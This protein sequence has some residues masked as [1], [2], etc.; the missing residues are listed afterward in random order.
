VTIGFTV[1]GATTVQIIVFTIDT[2]ENP[3][4]T[5]DIT[6]IDVNYVDDGGT[7]N[8]S[9]VASIDDLEPDTLDSAPTIVGTG[10]IGAVGQSI[11]VSF[12]NKNDIPSNGLIQLIFPEYTSENEFVSVSNPACSSSAGMPATPTCSFLDSSK[13]LTLSGFATSSIADSTTIT[14]T[15]GSIRNP[16][17]AKTKYGFTIYTLDQDSGYIDNY[18]STSTDFGFSITSIATFSSASLDRRFQVT[19]AGL[20]TEGYPIFQLDFP[21]DPDCK[22]QLEFASDMPVTSDLTSVSGVGIFSSLSNLVVDTGSNIVTVEGC[23]SFSAAKDPSSGAIF[24]AVYMS[25]MVN[26]AYVEETASFTLTLY[27]VDGGLDY[28]IAQ[29]SGLT[30]NDFTPA[31]FQTFSVLPV[32][33][34]NVQ[35]STTYEITLLPT[36]D[37]PATNELVIQFPADIVLI[38]GSCSTTSTG[39]VTFSPDSCVVAS[40]VITLTNVFG[41]SAYE[42]TDGSFSFIIFSDSDT[43][44][45]GTNPTS[46]NPSFGDFQVNSYYIDGANTF[47]IDE[48]V[49]STMF[50]PLATELNAAV[51]SSSFVTCT[52]ATSY[53]LTLAPLK[54]VPSNGLLYVMFPEQILLSSSSFSSC[55]ASYSGGGSRTLSCS[56]SD[57]YPVT[58]TISNVFSSFSSGTID[59]ELVGMTN[60]S[61]LATT[62][63]FTISTMDSSG[64]DIE[65]VS[66]NL[67]ITMIDISE[68]TLLEIEPDNFTTGVD[69]IYTIT[70]ITPCVLS[71]PTIMTFTVPTEIT[72]TDIVCTEVRALRSISCEESGNIVTATITFQGS[73]LAS[74]A[75][76]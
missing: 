48:Q 53:T 54:E 66:T 36:N 3:S 52:S 42:V 16:Y 2:F 28:D 20:Q 26:K 9:G 40:N 13:T 43:S 59:V 21:V 29:I 37:I 14:F 30:Y 19:D 56:T 25:H 41:G 60:P 49:A 24:G 11:T 58:L 61:T 4:S 45:L 51:T 44:Q 71:N 7:I 38:S 33:T 74:G 62:D 10:I 39:T 50:T 18:S 1:G 68:M 5:T 73:K 69:S 70:A 67:A 23:S 46:S 72:I 65:T 31:P 47:E 55:Q 32:T 6:N 27:A 64:Y 76:F 12:V 15:V 8:E 63:S 35:E 22:L 57:K 34:Y 75:S 17:N